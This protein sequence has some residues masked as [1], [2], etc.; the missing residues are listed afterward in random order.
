MMPVVAIVLNFEAIFAPDLR[1]LVACQTD[2]LNNNLVA[3]RSALLAVKELCDGQ[4]R[5]RYRI[6]LLFFYMY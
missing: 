2:L 3:T 4:F 5:H 6:V 1:G